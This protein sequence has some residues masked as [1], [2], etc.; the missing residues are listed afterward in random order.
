[1][2]PPQPLTIAVAVDP[3]G[4]PADWDAVAT[5]RSVLLS[6]RYLQGLL[7]APPAGT[8]YRCAWASEGDAVV[9]VAV[10]HLVPLVSARLE[11]TLAGLPGPLRRAVG[12]LGAE[13]H[14]APTLVFCGNLLHTDGP[15]FVCL[16]GRP[17][18]ALLH[19]LAEAA[20]TAADPH[21]KLVVA[22]EDRWAGSADPAQLAA[23]GY[24]EVAVLQ[25]T[26]NLALDPD[27]R[28]WEDYLAALRKKYRQRARAARRRATGL[29]RTRH[30][31]CAW[32][33][34]AP[35]MHRLLQPVLAR[36]DLSLVPLSVD[37][38]QTLA[39][40][41]ED[42]IVVHTYAT[43]E[44]LLGFG[45]SIADGPTLHAVLVGVDPEAN[46]AHRLYQNL[47]YDFVE[48]AMRQQVSTLALGRTALEIKSTVGAA[49]SSPR[50][51]LRH[52]GLLQPVLVAA[53][54]AVPIHT[55]TPRRALRSS[56]P[57]TGQPTREGL[58]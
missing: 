1:M 4:L 38:L 8:T 47:L 19:A 39:A 45:L 43:E 48:E 11:A 6:R 42:R 52:A 14:A 7:Q 32:L 53:A 54:R 51:L 25:P 33:R 58:R 10:F 30:P 44:Q 16:P 49:A 36:A 2:S 20:R 21:H 56:L 17:A 15:G 12:L 34:H 55:W 31:G 26:M 35:E 22:Q 41:L 28:T 40:G 57:G 3:S 5:Q 27:W 18:A 24:Q 37:V 29:V 23:H 13:G 46:Q 9:A 50:L